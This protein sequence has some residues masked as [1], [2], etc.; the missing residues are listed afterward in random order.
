MSRFSDDGT[1]GFGFIRR[2]GG[3]PDVWYGTSATE[4]RIISIGD[5]VD[6]VEVEQ[7]ET[8]AFRV[9]KTGE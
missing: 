5:E 3:G 1:K 8:R 7:N 2:I 6:F 9:W 4:G